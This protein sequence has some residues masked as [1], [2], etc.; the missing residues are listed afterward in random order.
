M[1]IIHW[2]LGVSDSANIDTYRREITRGV[3]RVR[4]ESFIPRQKC[5]GS[6]SRLGVSDRESFSMC[7]RELPPDLPSFCVLTHAG[8]FSLVPRPSLPP[9][10]DRLHVIHGRQ[11]LDTKTYSHLCHLT[12]ADRRS[13]THFKEA[14][15]RLAAEN[16]ALN[17][18]EGCFNWV[19]NGAINST[20]LVHGYIIYDKV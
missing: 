1:S 3:I 13:P 14:R 2:C 7:S 12:W 8:C 18:C 11:V 15:S 20:F 5:S 9:V 16:H 10:F 4:G 17:R 19:V 6:H